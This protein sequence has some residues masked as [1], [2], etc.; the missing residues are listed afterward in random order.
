MINTINSQGKYITSWTTSS[1]HVNMSNPSAGILRFNGSILE[2]FDGFSWVS[3]TANATVMLSEEAESL[4]DWAKQK[5]LEEEELNKMCLEYPAL[6][7]AR[8]TF[9]TIK[10]IVGSEVTSD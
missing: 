6:A 4:L 5:R 7:K 10:R 1:P 9:E 2:A 8:E 3:I